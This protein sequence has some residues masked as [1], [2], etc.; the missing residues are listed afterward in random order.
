MTYLYKLQINRKIICLD[1]FGRPYMPTY[2]FVFYFSEHCY[3]PSPCCWFVQGDLVSDPLRSKKRMDFEFVS[4]SDGKEAVAKAA[5]LLFKKY[6]V[7]GDS[8]K[9]FFTETH[10]TEALKTLGL[11]FLSFDF[12]CA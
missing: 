7:D 6:Y 8:E 9:P 10:L 2:M 4:I 12:F 11:L 3:L 5:N 1:P